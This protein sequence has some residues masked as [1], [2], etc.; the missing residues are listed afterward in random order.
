MRGEVTWSDAILTPNFTP[1]YRPDTLQ[2]EY[3][4]DNQPF[5]RLEPHAINGT[6]R[7]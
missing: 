3:E 1:N 6:G 4:M 2:F 5:L 7:S